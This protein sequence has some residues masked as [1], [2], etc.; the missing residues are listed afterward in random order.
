MQT[1]L[2]HLSG[3]GF[4]KSV[5]KISMPV[6]LLAILFSLTRHDAKS[7]STSAK[8]TMVSKDF[9]A[10]LNKMVS[11]T[12]FNRKRTAHSLIGETD[13][14]RL[15]Q[16]DWFK[17]VKQDI[18]KRRYQM[19]ADQG[20]NLISSVNNAQNLKASY[21]PDQFT[22]TPLYVDD[23]AKQVKDWQ[24]NLSVNGLYADDK[25]LV[26]TM[27][28]NAKASTDQNNAEYHFGNAL[29]I[30][31]HNDEHGVRQNFIVKEKPA[32][33]VHE[34]RVSLHTEGDWVVDKVHNTEIHFAKAKGRDGLE[35]KVT[36]NG[37]K[38]WDANGKALLAKMEVKN[39]QR[40]DI[41]TDVTD[42]VYPVT[43]DPLSTSAST[44]LSG[45][46]NFGWS[47]ASAGDVNGDGYSDVIVGD[48]GGHAYVYSGSAS[49]L[50]SSI[51]TTLSG[52][53]NYFGISVAGA[54][55]VDGDGYSDVIVGDGV[56]NAYVYYGAS[57]GLNSNPLKTPT[58]I[59]GL[60]PL[61]GGAAVSG[62]GDVNGDGFSDIMVSSGASTQNVLIYYGASTGLATGSHSTLHEATGV[63]GWSIATAGDVNGDG[64]SDVIVGDKT[65]NA[66]LYLGVSSSNINT[67][68]AIKLSPGAASFGFTVASA[69]DVNGDGYSD[70]IIG[71]NAGNAY[72]YNGQSGSV[73]LITPAASTLNVSGNTTLGN[74]VASAGDVN[75]DAFAD[76]IVGDDKGHAYVFTGS[77]SGLSVSPIVLTGT[78]NFG[79]SVASAGDV[80]GDG[81]S[82]VIVGSSNTS[83]ALTYQGGPSGS[84]PISNL[85]ILG[86]AAGD[87]FGLSVASAG[88][89]NGDGYSDVIVGAIGYNGLL[90]G[91]VYI[92]TG[93][94]NGLS[95]SPSILTPGGPEAGWS[96]S[97]A[98]DIN[99]DGY[100]DILIGAR[101]AP[102]SGTNYFNQGYVY[103]YMGG[104]GGIASGTAPFA[105]LK[106]V[107]NNDLFGFSVSSAGDVNGDGYG[108]IIVGAPGVST[109]FSMGGAAYIYLGS[110]GG[111]TTTTI[112][113]TL[114]GQSGD[115][116]F[117]VSVA[118]AGDINGDGYGDVMVGAPNLGSAYIIEDNGTA[119]TGTGAGSVYVYHGSASGIAN[120]ASPNTSLSDA[121]T[122]D[123]GVAVASAGD[124][125]GDGYSDVVI[126]ASSAD[127][128]S[129]KGTVEIFKGSASGIVS[130][131]YAVFTDNNPSG[132]GPGDM[133]GSSVASAGDVNGDGY[134]DIIV[135][136][137]QPSSTN[138]S[139]GVSYIYLGGASSFS[140]SAATAFLDEGTNTYL[141]TGPGGAPSGAVIHSCVG[142]AGDVN[143]DGYSDVIVGIYEDA[144]NGTKAGKSYL[145][146]GNNANGRNASNV[147]KLYQSDL[148]TP[149]NA[150]NVPTAN[151]GLG[152]S[153]KSPFGA[154]KGQMVWETVAN[155]QPFSSSSVP[156]LT[157]SVSYSASSA[158]ALIAPTGYEFKSLVDKRASVLTK[159][160][161]RIKYA[162]TAVTFGQVYGPWV[163]SQ[164]YL[165]SGSFGALPMK[166]LKFTAS[167]SGQDISLNW[168]TSDEV[169]MWSYVIEH[170]LD[171]KN[172]D[173]IGIVAAKGSLNVNDYEFTH[174]NPGTGKHYYRLRE[175]DLDKHATLSTDVWA[176][177][178]NNIELKI[179]PN[180]TS[181]YIVI[182]CTG[183]MASYA[184]IINSAGVVMGQYKLDPSGKTTIS[185]S[186]FAK[187]S[188]FVELINSGFAPSQISVQ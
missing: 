122:V 146:Y 142:S 153:T 89:I 28:A 105:T 22:L 119:N 84:I 66:Y 72:V 52:P 160:R 46:G 53:L 56:G 186:G 144:T 130:T 180:P 55:D 83:S 166:L 125:N 23:Q 170:S 68:A 110:G 148:S 111:I 2:H 25:L 175:V 132:V 159:V 133:F 149:L 138:S 188:Y 10:I 37:L 90:S 39:N 179:Y 18:E 154:V 43:I 32:G 115:A 96:V 169:N 70:V 63:Y 161:A 6:V 73:G 118:S 64:N 114:Y 81:Y 141:E 60:D 86:G 145:Y 27:D 71:D 1:S 16:S 15:K 76:V 78:N 74:S 62:A 126:G 26:N 92:Y 136:A 88:D 59:S 128:T 51:A 102:N 95:T 107:N 21:R 36:Y 47:V 100:D 139:T 157:N 58:V 103:I 165:S 54:G 79:I 94:P 172:F 177:I 45:S 182:S 112:P 33:N 30:Q 31:Y 101:F 19:V 98:G 80:N 140:T 14:N 184:R 13:T 174:Y 65:G 75:G 44:S 4:L 143:G 7:T 147:L 69:G 38:A 164:A 57:A 109:K 134:S 121:V 17:N 156:S 171:G 12:F 11:T 24:L 85:P 187:G 116:V 41:I 67:I 155:G 35:N 91:A 82:D 127:N 129:N 181:D 61:L 117:G 123:F 104:L 93:G 49:G 150:T 163:Y 5:A 158:A 29:T 135:R 120:N 77:A 3:Q 137:T 151:F 40:F 152:L 185:L 97:G 20:A 178:N 108:D 106:G 168:Q 167:V 162:P 113:D 8:Q 99:G 34:L 50:S 183:F 124:V 131:A 48:D 9:S 42:A 173:S 87:R 176:I